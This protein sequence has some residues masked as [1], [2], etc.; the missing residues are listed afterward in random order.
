MKIAFVITNLSVGGAERVL[1]IVANNFANNGD[2]VKVIMLQDSKLDYQVSEKINI[3]Y[4]KRKNKGIIGNLGRI[5][6][7]RRALR[8]Y[9]TVISFLWH[10]N[11]YTILATRFTGKKVI[12]SDRSD[13]NNE[14]ENKSRLI[15]I[16]RNYI[17]GWADKIVF[18]TKAAQKCYSKKIQSKSVVIANPITSNLPYWNTTE[19]KDKYICTSCR[20]AKQKNLDMA[21][22]AFK[23]FHIL[24][25]DYKYYIYGE[26][27]EKERLNQII[28][29]NGLQN[30]I[31]LKGFTKD[32]FVNLVDSSMFVLSSD[33]EGI[34]NSMLE[35]I[36]IGIPCI[37]TDSPPGGARQFIHNGKNGFLI[38]VG[39]D[40]ALFKKM[41]MLAD[42]HDVCVNISKE[43]IKIREILGE[44]IICNQ[45]RKIIN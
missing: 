39:D 4:I 33:Y 8:E 23:K 44:K 36:A 3:Q 29:N 38:P 21:I 6:N 2:D 45:W 20:L 17:Y 25:P 12:I 31:F 7:L 18:Q 1:S 35:A 30:N 37:I 16:I 5:I 10:I 13:P 43:A 24:Y 15:K 22:C 42:N 34:S 11:L 32:L 41:C 40:E 14:L 19:K 28:K 27:P 9:N 26:G